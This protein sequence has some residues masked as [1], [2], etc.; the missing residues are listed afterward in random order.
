MDIQKTT[1]ALLARLSEAYQQRNALW[2]Q[3]EGDLERCG[4]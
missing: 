3:L 2:T 4:T 1:D